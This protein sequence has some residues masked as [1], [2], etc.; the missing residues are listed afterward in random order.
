MAAHGPA[1]RDLL[2][3]STQ[4]S[5]WRAAEIDAVLH[6]ER[7]AAHIPRQAP[8]R[9]A[10]DSLPDGAMVVLEHPATA[11]L[12]RGE[13]LLQWTAGGY[14][15]AMPRPPGIETGVLTPRCIVATFSAGY[16]PLLHPSAHPGGAAPAFEER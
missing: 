12:V 3:R 1:P 7:L 6:A 4:R 14:T 13:L 8:P 2:S 11:W 15:Q 5:T 16:Q 9:M 10:L